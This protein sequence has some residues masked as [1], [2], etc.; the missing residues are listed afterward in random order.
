MK[1]TNMR[2]EKQHE[3]KISVRK[4]IF[5]TSENSSATEITGYSNEIHWNAGMTLKE[6][7]AMSKSG[8]YCNDSI[9]VEV[10]IHGDPKGLKRTI[11]PYHSCFTCV[12]TDDKGI[13]YGT[14]RFESLK[15]KDW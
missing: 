4:P 15:R 1:G 8:A 12:T 2:K 14:E 3:V 13:T 7:K 10:E 5:S 9:E 6:L 11:S